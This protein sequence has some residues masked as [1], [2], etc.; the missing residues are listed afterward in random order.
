[1]DDNV[2]VLISKEDV[3]KRI[4][5]LGEQVTKDYAGKEIVLI[6]VLKGG[7]F[8]TAE[9]AKH[10]RLPVYFDFM[11]VSSYGNDSVST[12]RVRIVKD[13]DES[14]FGKD[15]ILVE[16]IVDTGYT[17]TYIVEVLTG[18]KPRSLKI[19][20]LLDKPSRRLKEVNVDYIGFT[21]PDEFV[22]GY[23]LDYGQK[24]RN[25]PYIGAM[26]NL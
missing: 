3:D 19:C 1:M 16:D 23:G 17:L 8:F 13:I 15:V 25:L 12:G 7:M 18:K 10:I 21:I 2:K 20:A 22:V 9:L 14:I 5:E 6:C 4:A 11:A 24:Y 26:V